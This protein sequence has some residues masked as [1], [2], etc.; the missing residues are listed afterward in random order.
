MHCPEPVTFVFYYRLKR[1]VTCP[2]WVVCVCFHLNHII[3]CMTKIMVHVLLKFGTSFLFALKKKDLIIDF[4][5][6]YII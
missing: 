4:Y 2:N 1:N 3:Y 6:K 5:I